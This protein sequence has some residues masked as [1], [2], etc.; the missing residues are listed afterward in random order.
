VNPIETSA[1]VFVCVF[2]GA[3]IGM[4]LRTVLPEHHLN[5]DTKD[6]VKLGVGLIGT[7]TAL[8]LGLMVASAKSSYDTRSSE[9]TTMA[10]DSILLDR[11]FAHYGPETNEIR[12]LL[13]VALGRLMDQLWPT[14]GNNSTGLTA[15]GHSE[16]IFDKIQDLAPRNEAQTTIRAQ[17]LSMA[18]TIAQTRYLLF[19]QGGSSISMTFL[20]VVVFWLSILFV[21][22]GMFAPSNGTVLVTLLVSAMSV[23]GAIFL[24]VELDH[25]F[26]GLIQVS[27]APLRNALA[28][29]G[30]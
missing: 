11:E 26:S 6:V 23:A 27:S 24:I 25:P 5:N 20:V 8:V 4:A 30:K 22:F 3:M 7:M 2:G 28:V 1:V 29:L 14:E 16:I 17:A 15:T 10:A 9:I 21:S 13:K 19:E 12:E 18:I